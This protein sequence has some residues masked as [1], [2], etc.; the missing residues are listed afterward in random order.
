MAEGV[1]WASQSCNGFSGGNLFFSLPRLEESNRSQGAVMEFIYG[2]AAGKGWRL[3]G[4]YLLL[5][6]APARFRERRASVAQARGERDPEPGLA[7]L[8]TQKG[9]TELF[10]QGAGAR[11]AGHRLVG[12]VR[13]GPYRRSLRSAC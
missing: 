11:G 9:R 8:Q 10:R 1:D 13:A 6:S 5:G 12:V 3:D 7:Q 4:R 2:R